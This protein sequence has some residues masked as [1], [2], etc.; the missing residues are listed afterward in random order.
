MRKTSFALPVILLIILFLSAC[1]GSLKRKDK[2]FNILSEGI[3]NSTARININ[4]SGILAKLKDKLYKPN[5][6]REHLYG[7]P[8]QLMLRIKQR[9]Y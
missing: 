4:T 9:E 5:L 2:L 6:M 3:E 8:E 1:T 7:F